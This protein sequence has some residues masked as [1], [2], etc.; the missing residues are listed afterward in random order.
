VG[1]YLLPG[2]PARH[3]GF[4]VT[5]G[6][7][8]VVTG[9]SG[10]GKTTLLNAIAAALGQP[11]KHPGTVTSVLAD[12]Y[13]FTGTVASNIRL[14]SPLSSDRDIDDLLAALLLDRGGI[15]PA[16]PAGAGGRG[17]SGGEQRRLHIARAL[18]TSPDVLLIDEPVTSLDAVT[19]SQALAAAR[20]RLPRAV[21]ILAMHALPADTSVLGPDWTAMPLDQDQSALSRGATVRSA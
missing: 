4:T 10:S 12:D 15:R 11:G 1:A 6:Q 7:T 20:Q 14:A 21:L 2:R 9:A 8:L 13:L 5:A 16:T 3:L 19:A 18:A 17:L